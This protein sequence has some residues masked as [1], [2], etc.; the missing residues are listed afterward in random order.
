MTHAGDTVDYRTIARAWRDPVYRST[1]G[2]DRLDA[3]PRHP[4][5][6]TRDAAASFAWLFGVDGGEI[7]PK[8]T[9]TAGCESYG[10]TVLVC[11]DPCLTSGPSCT[12]D[13]SLDPCCPKAPTRAM[14]TSST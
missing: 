11:T 7:D 5:G 6:D 14:R 10:C 8:I 1:I 9:A 3:I 12:K 4:A 13:S 2:E